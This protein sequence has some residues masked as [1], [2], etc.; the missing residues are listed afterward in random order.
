MK[1]LY[2]LIIILFSCISIYS[3]KA[4]DIIDFIKDDKGSV[5]DDVL[6]NAP[7]VTE[8]KNASK[9]LIATKPALLSNKKVVFKP[10]FKDL[11][12]GEL[13]KIS[14]IYYKPE[15]YWY[16]GERKR[17][18]LYKANRVG[19]N[20]K[21]KFISKIGIKVAETN[22]KIL[23]QKNYLT[24][25]SRKLNKKQKL[26]NKEI[27][28]INGLAENY[29]VKNFRYNRSSSLVELKKR[30]GIVPESLAIAQA[31]VESAWG[32]SR[33]AKQGNNYFGQWCYK[34]GCGIVPRK[35]DSG[36]IHEVKSFKSPAEAVEAYIHNL[37][38]HKAYKNF[39]VARA[40]MGS[41]VTGVE[42]ANYL[43]KYS[44]K[45]SKYG[46]MVKSIIF[47]NHLE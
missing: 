15:T 18:V 5:G 28:W 25:L 45:G 8:P 23:E 6:V 37:N 36:R 33:F 21:R 19:N 34:K 40:D 24:N 7:V 3:C 4:T 41:R 2:N 30:V 31:A 46:K 10:N 35:R 14:N 42:L 44:A 9:I 12:S 43:D 11:P 22:E 27:K 38:T 26:S 16:S 32:R 13:Y 39:R 20:F 1:R 17:K 47:K 29:K